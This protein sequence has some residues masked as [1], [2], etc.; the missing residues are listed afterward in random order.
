MELYLDDCADANDLVL[1]LQQAGHAVRTPRT[2]Q[3]R[4]VD[5]PVHLEHAAAHD[6]TKE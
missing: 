1:L 6:L 5:D 4:G 3:T 2:E